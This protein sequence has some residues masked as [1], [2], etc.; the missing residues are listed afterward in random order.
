M[1]YRIAYLH[2]WSLLRTNRYYIFVRNNDVSI[3]TL[4][5]MYNLTGHVDSE[6]VA[7]TCSG[8]LQVG[9]VSSGFYRTTCEN[10]LS[11]FFIHVHFTILRSWL[12]PLWYRKP[13]HMQNVYQ[14]AS[15]NFHF[16]PII[17]SWLFVLSRAPNLI[18]CN[19]YIPLSTVIVHTIFSFMRFSFLVWAMLTQ[20]DWWCMETCKTEEHES[21]D[22]AECKSYKRTL[23]QSGSIKTVHNSMPLSLKKK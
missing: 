17:W 11:T 21:H 14:S 19:M 2:A 9:S 6:F 4:K 16:P 13:Y 7:Y 15:F 12:F 23:K 20:Y 5:Y 10:A 22:W 1:Y 3:R 8:N 18:T